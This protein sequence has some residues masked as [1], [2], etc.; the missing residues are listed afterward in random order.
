MATNKFEVKPQR[1]IRKVTEE[2]E[3]APEG[4]QPAEPQTTPQR[5]G[6]TLLDFDQYDPATQLETQQK[7]DAIRD[8]TEAGK[9]TVDATVK[10]ESKQKDAQG[11]RLFE[12]IS[13]YEIDTRNIGQAAKDLRKAGRP[14]LAKEILDSNPWLFFGLKTQEASFAGNE[15]TMHVSNW[16]EGNMNDLEVIEDPT[17]VRK[18]V[19]EQFSKFLSENYPHISNENYNGLVDPVIAKTTPVILQG[20]NDAH[21]T[22]KGNARDLK[23]MTSLTQVEKSFLSS[24]SQDSTNDARNAGIN[25]S[26]KDQILAIRNNYLA[27]GGTGQEWQVI[28][29]KWVK[30]MFIDENND[31]VNDLQDKDLFNKV[32]EAL[33]FQLPDMPEGMTFLDLP[34]PDG[35]GKTIGDLLSIAGFNAQVA[36]NKKESIEDQK[37]TRE[38]SRFKIK[39]RNSIHYYLEGKTGAEAELVKT[40]MI[41]AL[42]NALENNDKI[43]LRVFNDQT[44]KVETVAF[45]LPANTDV[46]GLKKLIRKGGELLPESEYRLLEQSA[47]RRLV[48]NSKD[49][50]IDIFEKL[51]PGTEQYKDIATLQR[52]A[53]KLA[54]KENYSAKISAQVQNIT[55]VLSSMNREAEKLYKAN[56]PTYDKQQIKRDFAAL[57][58][59]NEGLVE[60]RWRDYI[61]AEL[62]KAPEGQVFNDE[63]WR[64]KVNDFKEIIKSDPIFAN[65]TVKDLYPSKQNTQREISHLYTGIRGE[66]GDISTSANTK[67]I[68]TKDFLIRNKYLLDT[69]A[70][71]N[72]YKE[73]PMLSSSTF[74]SVYS[75]LSTGAAIEDE[76]IVDLAQGFELAKLLSKNKDLTLLEF[77]NGQ[78]SKDVFY[79]TNPKR[80]KG[81][82]ISLFEPNDETRLNELKRR[83]SSNTVGPSSTVRV[84]ETPVS[85][86]DT[87]SINFWVQDNEN[88]SNNVN[89]AVPIKSEVTAIGFNS[90][91]DGNFI[92]IKVLESNGELEAGSTITI[93]HARSFGGLAVGQIL[94]PGN[95]LGLQHN[96]KTFTIGVDQADGPGAG[97]HLNLYIIG[98][99]GTRLSQDVVSRIFKKVLAPHLAI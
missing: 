18:L 78:G 73:N 9:L 65:P 75:F 28:A 43:Y 15:A 20:I 59:K 92:S 69:D 95:Y 52:N 46:E 50:L 47:L 85:N 61:A 1:Q 13:Q 79:W 32:R 3:R 39:Y 64:D 51:V 41:Q 72:Y 53:F 89:I 88:G 49:P 23:T 86:S 96:K 31:G 34:G 24:V 30:G 97:P 6:G 87:G 12:K 71:L 56:N 55:P 54:L 8:I 84:A 91:T 36:D 40:N 94:Y 67:L 83:L 25:K 19:S 63:W 60:E 44:G 37:D 82:T 14:D 27:T 68:S 2:A 26:A 29:G 70:I 11:K 7:I 48:A 62:L 45:D 77:L 10:R 90:G 58:E 16:V 81:D 4:G 98:P 5:R 17:T 38:A 66:E 99:D 76:A 74:G 80:N 21:R 57:L 22:Y 42:D 35:D 93:R 33:S